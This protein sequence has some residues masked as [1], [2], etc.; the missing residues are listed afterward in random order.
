MHIDYNV[1]KNAYRLQTPFVRAVNFR[2]VFE[3][4]IGSDIEKRTKAGHT[5]ESSLRL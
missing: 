5:D 2:Y 4:N 3:K 1:C